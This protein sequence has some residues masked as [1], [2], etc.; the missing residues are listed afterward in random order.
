M[1]DNGNSRKDSGRKPSISEGYQEETTYLIEQADVEM[2][3][4]MICTH[5]LGK[6][7][8][9]GPSYGGW[10]F[11][12]TDMPIGGDSRSLLSGYY[13][14]ARP[15]FSHRKKKEEFIPCRGSCLH[16][17]TELHHYEII[18]VGEPANWNYIQEVLG[19]NEG[20]DKKGM[21][22]LLD[23]ELIKAR[24]RRPALPL[25]IKDVQVLAICGL[26]N[27][28]DLLSPAELDC[29]HQIGLAAATER[30]ITKLQLATDATPTERFGCMD[31]GAFARVFAPLF[32]AA[33]CAGSADAM[34]RFQAVRRWASLEPQC[35][36]GIECAR[37]VMREGKGLAHLMRFLGGD[38]LVD[39]D[40]SDCPRFTRVTFIREDLSPAATVVAFVPERA[41]CAVNPDWQA[42]KAPP[43][44]GRA[45]TPAQQCESDAIVH[46]VE[47]GRSAQS[48]APQPTR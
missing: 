24:I 12:E 18:R 35:T 45:G 47:E 7:C 39:I 33:L 25:L 38:A 36:L 44:G 9:K 48:H 40:R 2:P 31:R 15:V 23:K 22:K 37:S 42:D 4:F 34:Q 46:A 19:S 10:P 30:P 26:I 32:A 14:F 29:W 8:Y 11:V 28:L 3:D 43:R 5:N 17:G 41:I 16:R 13:I 27:R 1:G 6:I 20:T 21:R